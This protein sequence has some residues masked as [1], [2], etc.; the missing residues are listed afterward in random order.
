MINIEAQITI[1]KA[2]LIQEIKKEM[3]GISTYKMRK[4][5]ITSFMIEKFKKYPT[6]LQI[7]TLLKMKR[8][9]LKIKNSN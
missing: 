6:E 8:N 5:G 4:Y 3:E 2:A 1:L 7:E 9:L